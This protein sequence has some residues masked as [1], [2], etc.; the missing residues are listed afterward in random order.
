MK[1]AILFVATSLFLLS[2]NVFNPSG[3]GDLSGSGADG[4][5]IQGQQ[6][7]RNR[8]FAAAR[9]NFNQAL[10]MDSSLSLAWHGL[11]KSY[12]GELPMDS[13]LTAFQKLTKNQDSLVNP[14]SMASD[15]LINAIYRPMARMTKVYGIFIDRDTTGRTDGIISSK[16]DMLNFTVG[17]ALV[18]A[19]SPMILSKDS[20]MDSNR[21]LDKIG[22]QL[23]QAMNVDSLT[24][25]GAASIAN[26]VGDLV[27]QVDS[28]TCKLDSTGKNVCKKDTTG[29]FDSAAVEALNAKFV[30]MG[31]DLGSI[32]SAAAALGA[33]SKD[34]TNSDTST[35]AAVQQQA[36]DFVKSN[37]DAVKLVQFADGLDNDGNGC[38]DEKVS[39]GKDGMGDG[40]PGDY[41]M[42]FRDTTFAVE[43]GNV[44]LNTQSDGIADSRLVDISTDTLVN[45]NH[46]NRGVKGTSTN[47]PLLYADQEGHL[48]FSR[49]YWD[50]TH[51]DYATKHWKKT[52]S[53]LA[54][55]ALSDS[56]P[57]Y[58]IDSITK[59]PALSSLGSFARSDAGRVLTPEEL[60]TIR[61]RIIST[62][63]M[64]RRLTLGRKY[65][66]GCW[67]DVKA[68]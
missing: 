51:S 31:S 53:W 12:V 66:G 43:P 67:L 27:L 32:Q 24:K 17:K 16:N 9:R 23:T 64:A 47:A 41:R 3:S 5:I 56:I 14:F 18:L 45:G 29:K 42:G 39:D 44:S 26:T 30:Q 57:V 50:S 20:L 52:L 46:L 25:G 38:V 15:S 2:C 65:V 49:P 1:R 7:L 62:T 33:T 37:P 60:I 22:R 55:D 48:E 36:Q 19:I 61:L 59:G 58:P 63:N 28:S 10:A 8:D 40:V 21:K 35:N 6:D 4:Y 68:P 11:G 13:V 34:S 54:E